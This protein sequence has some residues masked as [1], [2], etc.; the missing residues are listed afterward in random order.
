MKYQPGSIQKYIDLTKMKNMVNL[1]YA[2]QTLT[3]IS[4]SKSIF[5]FLG[6]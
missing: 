2:L 3:L 5:F 6:Q 1:C 4:L